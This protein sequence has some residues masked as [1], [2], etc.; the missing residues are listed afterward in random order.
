LYLLREERVGAVAMA[1]KQAQVAEERAK[2]RKSI[3]S[4]ESTKARRKMRKRRRRSKQLR[5]VTTQ[6]VDAGTV[7]QYIIHYTHCT[8]TLPFWMQILCG[9]EWVQAGGGGPGWQEVSR[10]A[11][12]ARRG[13]H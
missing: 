6:R 9:T 8:H 7:H 4:K 1:E 10:A 11:G 12:G 13:A 5:L 2:E 3:G